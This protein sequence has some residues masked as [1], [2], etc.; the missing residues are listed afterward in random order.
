MSA[1]EQTPTLD[2]IYRKFGEASEASQLLE[3]DLGTLLLF[4]EA[5]AEGM[6]TDAL[7]VDGKRA[8]ELM[9]RI[10]RQTFGQLLKN[11]TSKTRSL[12]ELEFLLYD[13][14]QKRNRLSHSFYRQH[15]FRRNSVE[16]RAI[17]MADLELIHATLLDALKELSLLEGIDLEALVAEAALR[18]NNE[19][20]A[21][22]PAPY[23]YVQI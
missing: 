10:N 21:I 12:D 8:T 4:L 23:F 11:V 3:T 18:Q 22:E 9:S 16:G 17:M 5:V 15:N 6:I 2:G 7:E 19:E 20:T 1:K 14:L 13:A